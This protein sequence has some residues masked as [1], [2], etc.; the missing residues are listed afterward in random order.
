VT[1][2]VQSRPVIACIA[3]VRD[4][5]DILPGFLGHVSK[6][7]DFALFVDHLSADG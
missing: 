4:E 6:L 3:M 1:G 5:E 2:L 7:F